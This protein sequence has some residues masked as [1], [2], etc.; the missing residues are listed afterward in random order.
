MATA[1]EILES[2]KD[3]YETSFESLYSMVDYDNLKTKPDPELFNKTFEKLR[4]D[5]WKGSGSIIAVLP[6][7][8]LC[9]R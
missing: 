1:E 4:S 6:W 7:G 9:F 2:Q 5:R 3:N 8:R